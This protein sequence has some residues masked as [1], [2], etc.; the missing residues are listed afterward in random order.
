[1][2][3]PFSTGKT[4]SI[5]Q[6]SGVDITDVAN[7]DFLQYN[8]T[9]AVWD[10]R[11]N[12]PYYIRALNTQNGIVAEGDYRIIS[13]LQVDSD[14]TTTNA[15]GDFASNAWTPPAGIYQLNLQAGLSRDPHQLFELRLALFKNGSA[16]RITRLTDGDTGGAGSEIIYSS[17]NMSDIIV[18]NGTDVFDF[19]A[20][21]GV[22]GATT[23]NHTIRGDTDGTQTFFSA[24][25]IG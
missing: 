16:I 3:I 5:N 8:S 7:N 2:T 25:K 1:M 10:N 11:V 12:R 14:V 24:Y 21:A 4:I 13:Y 20:Y 22:V 17:F 9:N 23:L 19:R 18:A 15:T 6:L